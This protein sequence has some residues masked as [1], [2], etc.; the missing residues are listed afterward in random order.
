MGTT[1]CEGDTVL[2]LF[3]NRDAVRVRVAYWGLDN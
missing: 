2:T 3:G 1:M